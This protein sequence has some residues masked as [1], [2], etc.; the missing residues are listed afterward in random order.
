MNL[1]LKTVLKYLILFLIGL[2]VLFLAFR[3]Q[4]LDKIWLE[5]KSANFLWIGIS[6]F[7]VWIAHILRALR[8]RMLYHSMRYPVSFWNTYH[9]VMVGYLANLALPRF[10]EIGRCTV[11][12]RT[13]K[14]PMFASIGTVITERLFDIAVLILTATV[15]LIF[16]DD[17][18]VDFLSISIYPVLEKK[19]S[20]ISYFWLISIGIL[21]IAL[22]VLGIY[23][24]RQKFGHKLLRI[25][26]NL[27]LGF[28]SY[29]KLKHKSIFLLYSLGI[30]ICYLVS[31]YFAFSAIPAT[32]Q[33]G[34]NAA[35]TAIVFSSFAMAAP[36]Q[37]GIG[38]FH[39]M[40]AQA[41]TLYAVSLKDGLAY[42]T[43]IHSSQILMVLPLGS[44]SL[45]ISLGH[46]KMAQSKI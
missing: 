19:I 18:I 29:H 13:E 11:I 30:W 26:V 15:M 43:I 9:A 31:I 7:S 10:G 37:G 6:A 40:V 28:S 34:I 23:W 24:L 45:F 12:H 3:G 41:L 20:S 22:T 27:R 16:Q 2:G 5:I 32:S 33:L 1:N 46:K 39:W 4:D 17:I 35:F 14:V 8:W 25:F 21:V 36:V 44:L 42:S 38:V